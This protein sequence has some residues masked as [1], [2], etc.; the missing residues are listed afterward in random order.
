MQTFTVRGK[1]DI[2]KW[3]KLET[4]LWA[5]ILR[6]FVWL[7][8][9]SLFLLNAFKVTK[10]F[11]FFSFAYSFDI[12]VCVFIFFLVVFPYKGCCQTTYGKSNA[13]RIHLDDG[14]IFRLSVASSFLPMFFGVYENIS[15]LEG[16]CAFCRIIHFFAQLPAQ[17]LL[18]YWNKLLKI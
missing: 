7:L 2:V 14:N 15:F 17:V 12:T 11:L 5:Y 18:R 9:L 13:L 16:M 10:Q 4:S 3:I 8:F 6:E 1:N